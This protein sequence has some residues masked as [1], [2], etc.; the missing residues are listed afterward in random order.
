M[1]RAAQLAGAR[2]LRFASSCCRGP[3]TR[4]ICWPPRAS[5]RCGPASS[6]RSR[7]QFRVE[8]ILATA[9]LESTEGRN[10]AYEAL[11]GVLGVM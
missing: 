5:R 2:D 6:G 9:D 8:R 4:P 11:R 1:L 10:R 3:A 7:R